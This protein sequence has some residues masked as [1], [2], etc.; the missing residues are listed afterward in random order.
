[1]SVI[2]KQIDRLGFLAENHDEIQIA[3]AVQVCRWRMNRACPQIDL[4]KLDIRST[5]PYRNRFEPK[6]AADF[7][8]AEFGDDKIL[9]AVSIQIGQPRIGD[10]TDPRIDRNVIETIA[11]TQRPATN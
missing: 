1:M 3:I 6:Q 7:F 4:V 2:Q 8:K 11:R 5:I 9:V 10:A